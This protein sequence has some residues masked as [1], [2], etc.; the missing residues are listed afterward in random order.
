MVD[1][2]SSSSAI[3]LLQNL[4]SRKT[5][6]KNTLKIKAEKP[7]S[8]CFFV[9]LTLCYCVIGGIALCKFFAYLCARHKIT[10]YL[11]PQRELLSVAAKKPAVIKITAGI[12][13]LTDSCFLKL[14]C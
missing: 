8:R 6:H 7:F 12:R 2:L 10:L 3:R 5:P 9:A 4:L 1:S 11:N 13:Y 14:S